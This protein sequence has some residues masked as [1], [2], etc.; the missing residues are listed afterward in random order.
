MIFLLSDCDLGA[1][2]RCDPCVVQHSCEENSGEEKRYVASSSSTITT[3]KA[4]SRSDEKRKHR[5]AKGGAG[6]IK[7]GGTAK[8]K[9]EQV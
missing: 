2:I 1:G 6:L 3:G 9:D 4:M 8:Q 7:I 5:R